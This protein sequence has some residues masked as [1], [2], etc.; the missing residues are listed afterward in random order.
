VKIV[1]V[2]FLFVALLCSCASKSSQCNSLTAVQVNEKPLVVGEQV[3][4][5]FTTRG[6]KTT[7]GFLT[8]D[9]Q[10]NVFL[11]LIGQVH[12][13]DLTPKE[14]EKKILSTYSNLFNNPMK[15]EL[16]RLS[17]YPR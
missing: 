13:A 14:A 10:G 16:T 3:L 1:P 7:S 12:V 6:E 2:L 9:S 8:I 11:H 15:V 5:I 17:T 4:V